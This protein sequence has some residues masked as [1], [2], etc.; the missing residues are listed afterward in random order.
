MVAIPLTRTEYAR[1]QRAA[2]AAQGK[3]VRERANVATY[4]R[5]LINL[6]TEGV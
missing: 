2:R 6:A 5:R 3:R 4:V 1:W